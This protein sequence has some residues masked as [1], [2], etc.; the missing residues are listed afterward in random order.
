MWMKRVRS[1]LRTILADADQETELARLRAENAELRARQDALHAALGRGPVVLFV[2]DAQLRY[3]WATPGA[4]AGADPTGRTDLDLPPSP[5]LFGLIEAKRKVIAGGEPLEIRSGVHLPGDGRDMSLRLTPIRDADGRTTGL[6]GLALDRTDE[7][8]RA[9]RLEGIRTAAEQAN[10]AKSRFLAAASHDLRQPFQAMRLFLHL[11][12]ARITD[13]G[14]AELATRLGEALESGEQLLNALLEISALEAATV[15]PS[16]ATFQAGKLLERLAGEFGP[17]AQEKGLGLR[18]V[19]TALSVRSDPVLLDR[20]LRNLLG[21]A[22]RY[23]ERGR[24]LLGV[25]RRGGEIEIQVWDTG[26]GIPADKRQAIFEEFVQLE[27]KPRDRRQGLGLGLAIVKRTAQLLGHVVTVSS[28][29][30]KGSCFAVRLPCVGAERPVSASP[31]ARDR[32]EG[33]TVIA[34][35]EDDRLQLVALEEML[36]EWGHATVSA[37]S[38]SDIQRLLRERG[39][40]PDLILTDYRLPGGVTGPKLVDEL[41][42]LYGD[43]IPALLLTGDTHPDTLAEAERARVTVVHKPIHP[44]RLKRAIDKALSANGAAGG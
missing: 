42:T 22:L 24:I 41:R 26:P 16:L 20:I 21:N 31:P 12:E 14:Q 28:V 10:A 29:P 23:A 37:G 2:Q 4:A 38:P 15:T 33:G 5:E 39:R 1:L 36:R 18:V 34:V 25:R 43:G 13:P 17:Q 32:A 6:V 27:D 8:A 11:L 7:V 44:N 3:L 35:V 40:P 30:G 9:A 19:S